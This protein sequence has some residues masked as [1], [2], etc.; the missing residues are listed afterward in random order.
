MITIIDGDPGLGKSLI[1]L[2]LATAVTRGQAIIPGVPPVGPA[3]VLILAAEDDPARTIK[4]RLRAAGAD[5]RRV[6]IV[7]GVPD[8]KLN[9]PLRLPEDIQRLRQEILR[10]GV[11]LV[12]IDPFMGF[13][14]A[15]VDAHKDQSV[16][17][18]LAAIKKIA[19]E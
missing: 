15:K 18:V 16:R 1:T 12:V 10:H 2:S 8:G 5:L 4:P 14:E 13:L 7:D 3:D 17:D 19:E 11:R 6:H 9:R